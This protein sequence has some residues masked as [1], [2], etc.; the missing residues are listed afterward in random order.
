MPIAA[1]PVTMRLVATRTRFCS[2]PHTVGFQA[3]EG[4]GY[5]ARPKPLTWNGADHP[6]APG[7]DQEPAPGADHPPAPGP[8]GG[9]E[10]Q[11]GAWGGGPPAAQ[12]GDVGAAVTAEEARVMRLLASSSSE[13][14]DEI[15]VSLKEMGLG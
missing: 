7:A 10:E 2:F 9:A 12:V 11:D 6:P 15:A 1:R 14:E 13:D 8:A 4:K 3:T 5:R